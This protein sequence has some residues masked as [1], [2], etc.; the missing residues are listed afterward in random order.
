MQLLLQLWSR[1]G[2]RYIFFGGTIFLLELAI[3]ALAQHAG[4]S[5]VIAVGIAF[6]LGMVVSFTSHKLVTFSDKRMHY[7]IVSLQAG[8]YS[9]LVLWNFGFTLLVTAALQDHVPA[10]VTRTIALL[11]TTVW[12][13]YLYKTK[14]FRAHGERP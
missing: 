8:L 11:V 5:S 13:F 4:A 10:T 14:I 3:I 6:W 9:L 1:P 2:V 12:N 7:R